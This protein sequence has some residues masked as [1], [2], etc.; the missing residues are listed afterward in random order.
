MAEVNK[1]RQETTDPFWVGVVD[2]SETGNWTFFD[3][4]PATDMLFDWDEGEPDNRYKNE[5]CARVWHNNNNKLY[6]FQCDYNSMVLCQIP[7]SC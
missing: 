3:G 6:D 7:I 2:P 4:E 5:I 1:I